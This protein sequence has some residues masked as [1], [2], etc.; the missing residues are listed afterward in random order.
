MLAESRDHVA[1]AQQVG[2]LPAEAEA[3]LASHRIAVVVGADVAGEQLGPLLGRELDRGLADRHAL[4]AQ[5]HRLQLHAGHVDDQELHALDRRRGKD[6]VLADARRT[7]CVLRGAL[8]PLVVQPRG[9]AL[10]ADV[11]DLAGIDGELQRTVLTQAVEIALQHHDL[12]HDVT[13]LANPVGEVGQQ[14]GKLLAGQ[15]LADGLVQ[16]L[17]E[18]RPERFVWRTAPLGRCDRDGWRLLRCRRHQPNGQQQRQHAEPGGKPS[19]D[20]QPQHPDP[21]MR[22]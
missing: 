5:R 22:F 18:Q 17:I 6:A 20:I 10:D 21:P 15:A 1:D 12:T 7:G 13:R 4:R 8:Q 11:A 19:P 14:I 3:V 16:R 2:E 9:V